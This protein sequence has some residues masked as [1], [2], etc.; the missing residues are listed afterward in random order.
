MK[1]ISF[2]IILLFLSYGISFAEVSTEKVIVQVQFRID[3]YS[4]AL[5]FTPEEYKAL[6][7]SEIEAMKA[8]R[9]SKHD[10][11]VIEESKK[12]TSEPEVENP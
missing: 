12:V 3:D 9:K 2:I 6:K 8:E 1:K 7:K 5:N 10:A 11:F 4:D